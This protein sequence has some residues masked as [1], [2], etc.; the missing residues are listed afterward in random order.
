MNKI[1][2]KIS[3][4]IISTLF[5]NSATMGQAL[6]KTGAEILIE[7]HIKKLEN[8]TIGLVMNPTARIGNVHVLDTLIN[9]QI[10]I[11]ALYSPEHGFR[12]QF[13]D[14]EIIKDGFDKETG[15]PVYSLY[16]SHKKPTAPM[17]EGIDLLLFDMQDVGARFYTFNTTMRYVIEA[18]SLHGIEVWILDRP[19]PA[20]GNYVSGWVL[21]SAF[22]S[23]VGS[24]YTP[25]AHGMTLGELALM[26]IGEGWYDLNDKLDVQIIEM[27]GW[28]RSMDWQQ[29]GLTWVPPSPNLPTYEHALVYLGTCFIEGTTISEGR[30]TNNPFLTIGAPDYIHNF[31]ELSR[32]E[33]QFSV[34]LDT[35]SFIPKSIP[36]KSTYPKYEDKLIKGVKISTSTTLKK[37]VEFGVAITNHFLNNSAD[38]EFKE[39]INLLVGYDAFSSDSLII[40]WQ[41]EVDMFVQLREKYLIYE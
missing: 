19:N 5:S 13:S 29:T 4:F 36:G 35:L 34:T 15:L 39:Y 28:K 12:G 31:E 24:H 37:P 32:L 9:L 14:G 41:N 23:M 17:L 22:E 40:N 30:G 16:G 33:K 7:K 11:K 20:G 1:Y 21:N 3:F 25:I 10:N 38:S 18:A 8:K 27:E 26:G 2:L 6:V